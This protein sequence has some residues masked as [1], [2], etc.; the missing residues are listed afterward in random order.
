[1][2]DTNIEHNVAFIDQ[3]E[4]SVVRQALEAMRDCIDLKREIG[5]PVRPET[6]QAI[7]E[8]EDEI[9]SLKLELLRAPHPDQLMLPGM[10]DLSTKEGKQE[11]NAS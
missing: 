6:R 7:L 9:G 1:M 11:A 2:T 8:L 10:E 3:R 5:L 4:L